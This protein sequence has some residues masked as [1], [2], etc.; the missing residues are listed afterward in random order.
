LNLAANCLLNQT[1][2]HLNVHGVMATI[3]RGLFWQQMWDEVA[4]YVAVFVLQFSSS[5]SY[6]HVC[7][8]VCMFRCLC[9]CMFSDGGLKAA[10]GTA[11]SAGLSQCLLSATCIYRCLYDM[12]LDISD[13]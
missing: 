13:R 4:R 11:L 8:P 2:R 6:C 12:A 1:V 9:L 10:T 7:L 3:L 5:L